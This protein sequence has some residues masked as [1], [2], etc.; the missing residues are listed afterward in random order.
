MVTGRNNYRRSGRDIG[1]DLEALPELMAIPD[2]SARVAMTSFFFREA[3]FERMKRAFAEEPPNL[4]LLLRTFGGSATRVNQV[5][6]HMKVFTDCI[7]VAKKKPALD[8]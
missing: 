4:S 5:R 3:N 7:S 8:D 1:I 6:N 2:I